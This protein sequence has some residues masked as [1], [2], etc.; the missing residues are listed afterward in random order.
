MEHAMRSSILRLLLLGA[1][2][3]PVAAVVGT[4]LIGIDPEIRFKLNGE[5]PA[6]LLPF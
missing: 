1:F 6:S 5:L 3:P 4:G 2:C